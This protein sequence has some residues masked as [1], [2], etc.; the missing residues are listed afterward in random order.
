[1]DVKEKVSVVVPVYNAEAYLERCIH[2]IINQTYGNVE[3]ILVDDG[4]TDKSYDICQSMSENDKRIIV[5]QQKNQGC[6]E[7][8]KT[9]I[10]Y[11]SGKFIMTVDSDDWIENIMIEELMHCVIQYDVDMVLSGICYDYTQKEMNRVWLDGVTPGFYNLKNIDSEIYDHFFL[12]KFGENTGRGIR[13][14]GT[15]SV[16]GR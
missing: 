5:H 1:M 13:G 2:S 15:C 11:A 4:S 16:S 6:M 14:D 12:E 8:R 10:G 9:G 7:A 3:I